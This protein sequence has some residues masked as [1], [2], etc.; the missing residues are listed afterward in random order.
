[1]GDRVPIHQEPSV[2]GAE[3]GT[4]DPLGSLDPDAEALAAVLDHK[5]F[6]HLDAAGDQADPHWSCRLC[7]AR[8]DIDRLNSITDWASD[9]EWERMKADGTIKEITDGQPR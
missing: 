9:M 4:F 1:M 3:R 6:V 7:G 8:R 5:C 2:S